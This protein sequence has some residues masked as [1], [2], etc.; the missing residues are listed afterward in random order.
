MEVTAELIYAEGIERTFVLGQLTEVSAMMEAELRWAFVRLDGGGDAAMVAAGQ[1]VSWLVRRCRAAVEARAGL[2]AEHEQDIREALARCAE[3]S[4]T[5]NTLIHGLKFPGRPGEGSM[6]TM[7][8][9]RGT[10]GLEPQ[11]WTIAT[12]RQAAGELILAQHALGEAIDAAL[13]AEAKE[14]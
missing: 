10:G 7:L 6:Q 8:S 12:M 2:E 5:R 9:R 13:A 4:R 14:H 3:A 11:S 1:S